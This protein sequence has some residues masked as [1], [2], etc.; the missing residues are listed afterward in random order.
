MILDDIKTKLEE[1][2]SKVYYGAVSESVKEKPWN[3]IVF[4]RSVM[5]ASQNKTGFSV[6]YSVHI[7]RE[8]FIPEGLEEA[9]IE[10]MLEIN[11]MRLAGN[12]CTYDYMTKPNTD[13]VVEMFS[14]D[15][16]RAKKKAA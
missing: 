8:E 6:I 12:D 5:R 1:I 3:Y 2:D 16:V 9:I 4:N 15:F 13:M 7:V 11:G 10:K 14:A